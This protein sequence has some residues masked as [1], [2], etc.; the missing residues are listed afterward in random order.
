MDA[1]ATIIVDIADNA[2]TFMKTGLFKP[3]K[4]F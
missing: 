1:T 2:A 3:L 4:K